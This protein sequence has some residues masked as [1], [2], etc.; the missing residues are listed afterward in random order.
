MSNTKPVVST[1]DGSGYVHASGRRL[2]LECAGHGS[3]TV[4]LEAGAGRAQSLSSSL[5]KW[6]STCGYIG[7]RPANR[8]AS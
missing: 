4:I 1:S 8:I 2:Y 7:I 3:P 5:C 6:S